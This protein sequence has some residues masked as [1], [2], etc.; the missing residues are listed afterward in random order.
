[1]RY[2]VVYEPIMRV[3]NQMSAVLSAASPID[4][5]NQFLH[6]HGYGEDEIKFIACNEVG[7]SIVSENILDAIDSNLIQFRKECV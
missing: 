2:R 4:A 6:F 7:T 5:I 1:M 3:A